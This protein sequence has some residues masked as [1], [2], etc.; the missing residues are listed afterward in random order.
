MIRHWFGEDDMNLKKKVFRFIRQLFC[1][2]KYRWTYVES[3]NYNYK[4][5][6]R[7]GKTKGLKK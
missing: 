1:W 6:K 5:C 7:C 2:H 3:Y 4:Y